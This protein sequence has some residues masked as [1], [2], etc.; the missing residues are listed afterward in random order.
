MAV[1]FNLPTVDTTYTAFPTQI[2]ENIDA[3]LQQL[4]VGSPSNVPTGAI[5]F[6]L[7]ANRWKKYNGSAYVDLTGTYDLNANL[8][9][10][11]INMG[12]GAASGNNA[13]MIGDSNDLRIYHDSNHSYIRD[14]SGTGNLKLTGSQVDI[15]NNLND[16]FMAKFISNG[17]VELY[18][19]NVKKFETS[20]AGCIITGTLTT[21]SGGT[22]GADVTIDGSGGGGKQINIGSGRTADGNSFI[23]LIGDDTNTTYGGRLIRNGGA[24]SKTELLH[25]G[26]QSLD[27]NAV[28]PGSVTLRTSN[29]ARLHILSGGD[30]GIGLTN[31][32]NKLHIYSGSSNALAV[33]TT[34]NGANI[35]L[36]DNDTQS[37]FRAVDGR[38]LIEADTQNNIAGSEIRLQIDGSQKWGLESN[39]NVTQTGH[40]T[41]EHASTEAIC[42][43][44]GFEAKDAAVQ[45]S[46]DQGDNNGDRW[47]LVSVASD[48]T[49]RFQNNISGSNVT[50]WT[51]AT[52]GDVTQVGNLTISNTQPFIQF[53]DTNNES[54]FQIGNAGGRFRIRDTDNAA[55]RI[56]VTT[57]GRVGINNTNPQASLDISGSG[58]LGGIR[59]LDSST[60]GGSPNFEIIGKRQDANN[61][62]AFAANIYLA[63]N[64]TDAKVHGNKILGNLNFGG[65]HT[66][67]NESNIS[68]TACIRAQASNSFD[69]KSDMP[70]DLVFCTGTAGKDRS[71]ESAGQ[72]NVGTERLRI[73]SNGDLHISKR[74]VIANNSAAYPAYSFTNSNNMGFYRHTQNQIGVSVGGAG[75]FRFTNN[76]FGPLIHDDLDLGSSNFKFDNIFATNGTISTSDQNLKNT[77]ATSD[78]GLDFINRLNPVSYKFNGKTRTHYGL[79]AQEIETVLGAIS[80]PATDFGG[81]CKDEK[82]DDGVDLEIPLYGLRYIEFIAPIIKAIQELSAKVAALE[83]A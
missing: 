74:I 11:Q 72:S 62:T 45:L 69:S 10:T 59:L 61:N 42:H 57:Q 12:D 58:D 43:V 9:V 16:E 14:F 54:D 52:D 79:I 15:I 18:E 24:N 8:S 83:A 38:L 82:D 80:K 31:P 26:T 36:L 39:G 25:R 76:Q 23:D 53:D 51:I 46:A 48:N 5:K 4:S 71:G 19:D 75:R 50:K 34:V 66:N 64:R 70:T 32:S 73:D 55:D 2:I 3:A 81:F 77:I 22:F 35:L 17:S 1:D 20:S 29:L 6:D 78:L 7:S 44:K 30:V 41:I 37:K 60:S 68:Y 47:K 56:S 65:N 49:L 28:D 27:I 40:L 67:G 63:G 13:I 33:Q 21:T